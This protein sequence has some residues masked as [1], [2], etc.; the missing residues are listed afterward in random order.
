[1]LH[2]FSF[3]IEI[4]RYVR[5]GWTASMW[6]CVVNMKS[7]RLIRSL[8][9][10]LD[11]VGALC[12]MAKTTTDEWVETYSQW[13]NQNV[14]LLPSLGS[15]MWMLHIS[16]SCPN[17]VSSACEEKKLCK[18]RVQSRLHALALVRLVYDRR[19]WNVCKITL[20]SQLK[21]FQVLSLHSPVK[22]AS[23]CLSLVHI[24]N[25]DL[26]DKTKR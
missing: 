18:S 6:L 1:M 11:V 7:A 15:M 21:R 16:P 8:L 19:Q 12:R 17:R 4:D 22:A 26:F 14:D 25:D 20:S 2:I 23:E 24:N 9:R 10:M 3:F 13:C 5:P